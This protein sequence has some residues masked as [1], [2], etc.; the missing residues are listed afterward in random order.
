MTE[1]QPLRVLVLNG[2]NLNLLG[3]RD[4]A[5][6]GTAT[7]ADLEQQVSSIAKELDV[8]PVFAQRNSEGAVVDLLQEARHAYDGVIL[9]P[10]PLSHYSYAVRDVIEVIDTPVMEVHISNVV[11]RE[12]HHQRLVTGAAA[13][14]VVLGCGF[15]GYELALRALVHRIRR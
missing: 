11:S 1:T 4:P 15:L 7:L 3:E 8:E 13:A 14:G 2:P 12:A 9:N 6:Y 5:H 10:G